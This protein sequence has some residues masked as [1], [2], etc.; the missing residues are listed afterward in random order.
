M[1][2]L[3]FAVVERPIGLEEVPLEILHQ[4]GTH[5]D[6]VLFFLR[7]E[8]NMTSQE[9]ISR[10]QPPPRQQTVVPEQHFH[11]Q[12]PV[13]GKAVISLSSSSHY[14]SLSSFLI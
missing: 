1:M 4:W 11:N 3:L 9:P 12:P 14:L 10:V 5:V 8:S 6:E 7:H 13:H 2:L